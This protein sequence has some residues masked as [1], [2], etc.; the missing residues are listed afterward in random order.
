MLFREKKK[1]QEGNSTPTLVS[2]IWILGC[3]I[4]AQTGLST[5]PSVQYK[6]YEQEIHK[7]EEQ[8]LPRPELESSGNF[9]IIG[10]K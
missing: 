3:L 5:G 10:T 1:R 7:P 2:H 8:S 9:A 6:C 4:Q